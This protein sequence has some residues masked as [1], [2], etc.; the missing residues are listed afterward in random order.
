MRYIKDVHSLMKV[1]FS[2]NRVGTFPRL[3]LLP[4]PLL[5]QLGGRLLYEKVGNARR[6]T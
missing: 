4:T 6:L 3:T 5:P 2:V 1:T